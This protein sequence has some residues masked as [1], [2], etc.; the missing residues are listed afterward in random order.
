MNPATSR[1]RAPGTPPPSRTDGHRGRPAAGGIISGTNYQHALA[2]FRSFRRCDI[3]LPLWRLHRGIGMGGDMFVPEVAG[4][5]VEKAHGD[6]LRQAWSEEFEEL[7]GEVQ[8]FEGAHEVLQEVKDRG[9][10]L[11]R[12]PV[13]ARRSMSRASWT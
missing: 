3:T 7:I 11:V 12:W 8:P 1:C 9:F 2:W 6:D 5:A 13:R 10:R 4:Q